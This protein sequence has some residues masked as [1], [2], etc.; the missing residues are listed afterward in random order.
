MKDSQQLTPGVWLD[1]QTHWNCTS[2]G[3]RVLLFDTTTQELIVGNVGNG[4]N[5][6]MLDDAST[7]FS[8]LDIHRFQFMLIHQRKTMEYSVTVNALTVRLKNGKVAF[9]YDG[10]YYREDEKRELSR[11]LTGTTNEDKDGLFTQVGIVRFS[12]QDGSQFAVYFPPLPD[13]SSPVHY[14]TIIWIRVCMVKQGVEKAKQE[15]QQ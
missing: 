9:F 5:G 3:D 14:L 10:D 11:K 7:C 15:K 6:S 8:Y 12:D 4:H 13:L 1:A 2:E